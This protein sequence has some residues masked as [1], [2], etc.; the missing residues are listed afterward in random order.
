MY[1]GIIQHR[2]YITEYL[3]DQIVA[4]KLEQPIGLG[5]I[6]RVVHETTRRDTTPAL[7]AQLR[8]AQLVEALSHP[9]G[10]WRDTAQR[11]LV[12]RG[13][14]SVVAALAE[15]ATRRDR[16][17]DAPARALDARRRSTRIE[18]ATVIKALD[19]PSRDVRCRGDPHRGALAGRSRT[20]RFS[21]A[22][23]KRIDDADWAVRQQLAASLGALPAGPRETRR[24]ALLERARRRSRSCSMP[25]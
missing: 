25:R 16:L 22:V 21:A 9:N 2:A 3:R 17:A 24:G 6:Y 23:L 8:R 7:S 20:S 10:W 5:R 11:L 13:D 18:P 12:E 19:D 15:L 1:R 4:R 14:E